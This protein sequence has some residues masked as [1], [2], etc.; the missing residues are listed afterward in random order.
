MRPIRLAPSPS[1]TIMSA[2]MRSSASSASPKRSSSSLSGATATPLAPEHCRIT[3]SFVD[4]CPSTEMRSKERL[5]Q[6]PSSSSAVSGASA[7]SVCTKQSI[8]AKAGS[9]IPAPLACA[10]RRTV[11]DGSSTSSVARLA[12]ASVVRIASLNA[13]SPSGL[14]RAAAAAI[15]ASQAV[16][17]Q[18]HADH[19]GRGDGDRGRLE[20]ELE[21][22]GGLH[23]ARDLHPLRAG[24]GVRV[25]GV[26][27]HGAQPVGRRLVARDEHRRGE[28]AGAGEARG[29]DA[30]AARRRR[31]GRGRSPRRP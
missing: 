12:N 13:S 4:S 6:T 25:A 17:R 29:A 3:V 7:A 5:T 9:I 27:D 30:L 28:H 18:R 26:R 20:A 10:L 23:R 8:V 21:R 1:R 22:G 15:P 16:R 14:R 11:P 31:A 2:S 19:A 24:R